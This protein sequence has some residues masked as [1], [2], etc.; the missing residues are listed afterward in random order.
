MA[1][2]KV[3]TLESHL[4]IQRLGNEVPNWYLTIYMTE[5]KKETKKARNEILMEFNMRHS[6]FLNTITGV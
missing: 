3:S 4:D 6:K 1:L 5:R 2:S